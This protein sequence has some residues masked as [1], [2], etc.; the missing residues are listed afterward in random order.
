MPTSRVHAVLGRELGPDWRDSFADFDPL[1]AA[2][3]SIG[4]VHRATWARRP[5]GGGQ[6]AVPGRRRGAALR[7]EADRPA[8]QGD[9]PAGRRHGRQRAGRGA[10]RAGQR[11]AR[12]HP[13]G[14]RPAAG[15]RGLR[16]Q[17]GVLRAARAGQHVPGDGQ[18]VGRGRAAVR[19]P[20]TCPT[21]S[22][23]RWPCATCGSCSPGRARSAC[24]TP[25]RIRATSRSCPTAGSGVVDFGLVA[26]LPD[27]LPSAMG[28]ILRIAQ[29]GRRPRG[30]RAA[31]RRGLR[32]LRRRRR[33][34]DG[35][36][37]AVRRAGRRAGVPVQPGLDARAVHPGHATPR[38][39][40]GW[41]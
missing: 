4:Q 32:R 13:G 26:R 3:A 20:P 2:A 8:V 40:A 31:A 14:R 15:G 1:P 38:P 34:P 35:L 29:H 33:G 11:G 17:R 23:T 7:P 19:R 9:V 36:S 16:G 24:C 12:L 41:R 6:G 30:R 10:D 39:P 18:R 37:G 25:T 22:A 27:G 5:A 28:R 21:T